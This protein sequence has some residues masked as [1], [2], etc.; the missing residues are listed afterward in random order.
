MIENDANARLGAHLLDVGV[1]DGPAIADEL[2]SYIGQ[3]SF[4][5]DFILQLSG[6]FIA[7]DSKGQRTGPRIELDKDLNELA[8]VVTRLCERR[9][10]AALS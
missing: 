9:T 10:S 7:I 8:T 6:S 5:A 3:A 2:D 4:F 1:V